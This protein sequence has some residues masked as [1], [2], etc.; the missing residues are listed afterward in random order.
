M[1]VGLYFGSF[2]P[3]HVGH[4]LVADTVA[5]DAGLDQVWFVVSPLSPF[6]QSEGM[7]HHF[8]RLDMVRLAIDGNPKLGATDIEFNM[9]QPSYT[10]H[11]LRKLT[12]KYPQH[13]FSLVMGEDNL[14][15][16][17]KWLEADHI[18]GHYK[19]YVYPRPASKPGPLDNHPNVVRV[20]APLMDISATYIRKR[21]QAAQSVGYLVPADVQNFIKLKKL[22]W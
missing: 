6:K 18:V 22:Y 19:V 11:T 8:D 3:I 7:A 13:E 17:H 5:S 4:L 14:T 15:H 16:L 9:P 20:Y 10:V 12:E 1:K 21:L 2:N